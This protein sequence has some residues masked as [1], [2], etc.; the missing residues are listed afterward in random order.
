[1]SPSAATLRHLALWLAVGLAAAAWPPPGRAWMGRLWLAH[2]AALAVALAADARAVRRLPPP[3]ARR[4]VAPTLPLGVWAPVRL[5]LDNE[6]DAALDLEV[7]DHHPVEADAEGLPRRVHLAPG[8]WTELEYRL[9]PRERGPA[10]FAPAEALLRSPLGLWRRR[11]RLGAGEPVRVLPNFRP[12]LGYALMAIEDRLGDL[13][14]RLQ[15]RRGEGTEFRELREYRPGDSPRRID[16]KATARRQKLTTREFQDERN[17]QVVMLIDCGRRMR[18]REA[19]LAHFDHVLTAVLLLT[20]AAARQGDAVGLATFGGEARWLA[21]VKGKAATAAVL[22]AVHDLRTSAESPDYLAAAAHLQARLR[23]RALV[24]VLTNLRDEDAG[25]LLPALALLRRRHL[26]VL[27]SLR[28]RALGE[29][30]AAE[31]ADFRDALAVAA[32]H[33]YLEARERAHEQLRAAGVLTLDVEPERLPI[34]AVNRYLEVK[35]SGLL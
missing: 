23:R 6:S 21:P 30:L 18:A 7:F 33:H 20:Y 2:G 17:Q 16:W 25:E 12:L 29:T 35:R 31:V 22:T 5:R 19:G 14:I 34:A 13:G 27:A 10:A 28:E 32:C 26:V 4:E 1:V 3:A 11:L 9:R 8:G 15:P 24:L